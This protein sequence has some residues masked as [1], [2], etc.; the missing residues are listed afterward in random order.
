[1]LFRRL[2][3]VKSVV[4]AAN[5]TNVHMQAVVNK[6]V[7]LSASLKLMGLFRFFFLNLNARHCCFKVEARPDRRLFPSRGGC[8]AKRDTAG[9]AR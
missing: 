7:N 8:A 6:A 4:Y 9:C 2:G 5:G 3:A 1:M